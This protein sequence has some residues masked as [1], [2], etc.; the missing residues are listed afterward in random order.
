MRA[1]LNLEAGGEPEI[2]SA[3]DIEDETV[4]IPSIGL[5]EG[6]LDEQGRPCHLFYGG[7]L[8][9][10]HARGGAMK[11]NIGLFIGL[12]EARKANAFLDYNRELSKSEFKRR[13]RL[14]GA[15]DD[16]LVRSV[17]FRPSGNPAKDLLAMKRHIAGLGV[18]LTFAMFDALNKIMQ[19]L[20]PND[21]ADVIAALASS[22]DLV[23][24]AWPMVAANMLDHIAKG[25][26]EALMP[27]GSAAKYNAVQGAQYLV[28]KVVPSSVDTD[29]Y[30]TI[31]CTKDQRAYYREG[32]VVARFNMGPHG[33]KLIAPTDQD[34]S[35]AEHLLKARTKIVEVLKEKGE[36][37]ASTLRNQCGGRSEWHVQ[38]RAD[39]VNADQLEWRKQ[40]K[41]V[42]YRLK[43]P[44]AWLSVDLG[45]AQ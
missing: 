8:N 13:L 35:E 25:A 14:F 11:T 36:L 17:Y 4:E 16:E 22:A 32:E 7:A 43:D 1:D 30:S 45:A 31:T 9:G 15:T 24:E 26:P 6:K 28:K 20:N 3:S 33:F 38:A 29:G 5:I 27:T 21:T 34:Q 10:M 37:S 23:T 39:M 40:G 42:F 18:P 19:G 12:Q 2:L 41:Q 44:D